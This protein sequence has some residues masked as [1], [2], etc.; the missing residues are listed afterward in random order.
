LW[1]A[2]VRVT[3]TAERNQEQANVV[4]FGEN[5]ILN[6][7]IALNIN[8]LKPTLIYKTEL[9]EVNKKPCRGLTDD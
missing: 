7:F 1:D 5:F 8:F 4:F 6:M 9:S 2:E 3:I